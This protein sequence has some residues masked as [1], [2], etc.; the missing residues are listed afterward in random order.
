MR[1]IHFSDTHLGFSE[2]AKVD[3][4]TGINL[5]EQDVYTA[6]NTIIA[7]AIQL[8]PDV[9]VH[10]G[11]LFHSPR[12]SNRA[13][14]V[15]LVGFQRLSEARIPVVLIAGNHS[16]PRVAATGSIFE[17]MS[18]LPGVRSAH[19][20]RYEFFEIGE[21][22]FHCVPHVS[23]EAALQAA[24]AEVRPDTRKRFNVLVM[25]GAVR[26]SGERYSL[27]E[28][29]EVAISK[30]ALGRFAGFDYV[31]LGH[32][33]KFLKVGSNAWYSGSP[34]RF[35]QNEAGYR[36]GFVE[37]DLATQRVSFHPLSPR[38]ILLLPPIRCPGRSLPEINEAIEGGLRDAIPLTGKIV[39]VRLEQIDPATWLELQRDRRRI[40][41]EYGPD[42]FEVR[43]DRSF[44]DEKSAKARPAGIGSLAMEF[45]AFM[46]TAKVNELNR[47]RLRKI[48]ECLIAEALEAEAGE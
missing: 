41:R 48:G 45:A 18:V 3:P 22:A 46:R 40:E 36:K 31:A 15:A 17:A 8:K 33:H 32:Y 19:Q 1:L 43:W 26:G 9:V 12:P 14:V 11:D 6:F 29:N 21:A 30:D 23:T 39:V 13:I 2:S 5:R 35:H 16:V 34:E 4:A 38:D 25:H 20:E 7:E 27:A 37:L 44:V 10:A 24:F 28:F 47:D 42:A